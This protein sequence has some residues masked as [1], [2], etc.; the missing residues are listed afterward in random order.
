MSSFPVISASAAITAAGQHCN[1]VLPPRVHSM[2]G[3]EGHGDLSRPVPHRCKAAAQ[4]M[5][6][7]PSL[8]QQAVCPS[9]QLCGFAAPQL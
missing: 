6:V 8:A 1:N 3:S 4:N 5:Q 7:M 9:T 2:H